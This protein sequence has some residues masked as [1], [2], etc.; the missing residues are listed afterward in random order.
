MENNQDNVVLTST[1]HNNRLESFRHDVG[2]KRPRSAPATNAKATCV[3]FGLKSRHLLVGDDSGAVCL[4]DLKKKARVRHY[5]TST[6]CLEATLDPTDTNVL[7]LT[8]RSLH[9]FRLREGTLSATI[10]GS[11]RFTKL[12]TSQLEP[13]T[14]A[15]GTCIGNIDVLDVSLQTKVISMSPHTGSVTAVAFS[16]VS[17]LLLA[18]ASVDETLAFFDASN[19][20][21]VQRMSLHSSATSMNF[22]NDGRTC[23]VG[24]ESGRVLLFDLRKPEE[25]I[26]TCQVDG[27]VSAVQ[28]VPTCTG[29]SDASNA[30]STLRRSTLSLDNNSN[31]QDCAESIAVEELGRVV[32]PSRALSA[33]GAGSVDSKRQTVTMSTSSLLDKVHNNEQTKCVLL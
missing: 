25:P 10:P 30:V 22:R 21:L 12:S 9:I 24:T 19:G 16:A 6:G 17:K 20:K 11:S 32:N 29:G 7:S 33:A 18:S 27:K 14:V 23:A 8:K 1:F 26:A 3:T 5:F 2:L 31:K 15:I 28:F 4:W 13:T